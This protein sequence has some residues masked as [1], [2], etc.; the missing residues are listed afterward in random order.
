MS[1]LCSEEG[2]GLL[3]GRLLVTAMTLEASVVTL[4][5]PSKFTGEDRGTVGNRWLRGFI[6]WVR[7]ELTRKS[8]D[9]CEKKSTATV[10]NSFIC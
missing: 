6:M 2:T 4:I 10:L 7:A 3:L 5:P 1:F 9:I 8:P